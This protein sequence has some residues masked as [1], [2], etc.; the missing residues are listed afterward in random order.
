MLGKHAVQAPLQLGGRDGAAGI[1]LGDGALDLRALIR[2]HQDRADSPGGVE[3]DEFASSRCAPPRHCRAGAE[4]RD[5]AI[6]A[7]ALQIHDRPDVCA[8]PRHGPPPGHRLW[9]SRGQ[10]CQARWRRRGKGR[11][12]LKSSRSN[13]ANAVARMKSGVNVHAPCLASTLFRRRSRSSGSRR[14]RERGCAGTRKRLTA[15]HPALRANL[16]HSAQGREGASGTASFLP[17]LDGQGNRIWN[18]R[19]LGAGTGRNLGLLVCASILICSRFDS[20]ASIR[21]R[22]EPSVFRSFKY[23]S[24]HMR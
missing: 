20:G 23:S 5:P 9:R 8:A 22:V 16:S 17:P 6:H 18:S 1:G 7:A 13:G 10:A 21:E 15:P 14:R 4:R 12:S 3:R 24:F 19:I 2:C 11:F